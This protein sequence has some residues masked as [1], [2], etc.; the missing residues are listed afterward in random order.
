[1]GHKEDLPDL[2]RRFAVRVMRT[3]LRGAAFEA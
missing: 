3:T 2:T 1:M